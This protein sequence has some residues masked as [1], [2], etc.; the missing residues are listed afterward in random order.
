MCRVSCAK[1]KY[2][3]S[4][5]QFPLVPGYAST[6]HAAQGLTLKKVVCDLNGC[7]KLPNAAYVILSRCRRPTDLWIL[8]DFP[9]TSL[10]RPPPAALDIEMRRLRALDEAAVQ[11]YHRLIPGLREEQYKFTQRVRVL[12]QQ[13]FILQRKARMKARKRDGLP[14]LP[15]DDYGDTAFVGSAY[16][17]SCY[18]L[19]SSPD[20]PPD[21]VSLP[22][23]AL[24]ALRPALPADVDDMPDGAPLVALRPALSAEADDALRQEFAEPPLVVLRPVAAP[25]DVAD[26]VI[27]VYARVGSSNAASPGTGTVC[28]REQLFI[29]CGLVQRTRGW[30]LV[31]IPGVCQAMTSC[32]V[33]VCSEVL[34]SDSLLTMFS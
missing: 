9:L 12:E 7:D 19:A 14:M 5:Q 32:A 2:R 22:E 33:R 21:F 25:V 30:I 11:R 3:I 4:R 20:A 26:S 27:A 15:E 8:R 24:E 1:V 10:Q 34:T 13:A 23:D 29:R 6:A 31:L 28:L 18:A 16:D 17:W